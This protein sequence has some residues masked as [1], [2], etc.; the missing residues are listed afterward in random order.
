MASHLLASTVMLRWRRLCRISPPLKVL[1]WYL[2]SLI[3]GLYL[4]LSNETNLSLYIDQLYVRIGLY[5]LN[6]H[7]AIIIVR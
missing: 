6:N 3:H 1:Y 7:A 2:A 4:I 5:T